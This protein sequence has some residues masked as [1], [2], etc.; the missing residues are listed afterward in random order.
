MINLAKK[1]NTHLHITL[2]LV[3]TFL[4]LG[5]LALAS[6][7]S[8]EA[9]QSFN[10]G[11]E[12]NAKQCDTKGNPVI[13]IAEKIVKTVDSGEGGNNWAFDDLNRQI[14]VWKNSDNTY[15]ALIQ[16]EGKFDSQEG[17][18]S[19]GNTGILTGSEDGTFKGGYRARI[20]GALKDNP[21]WRTNG[22]VGTHNYN[23]DISG[24]CPGY[25]NWVEQYFSPGY[26]FS[27]EWWG[28][29]YRYKNNTWINSSDGNSGDII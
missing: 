27:Y 20:T 22:S 25:L 18:K 7:K 13:N 1:T 14:K 21:D 6:A 16:N 4:V 19:P 23:C 2:P 8:S 17:Q 11:K 28:W 12:L 5:F 29:E 10:S 26:T 9:G 15:C 3:L 24:N